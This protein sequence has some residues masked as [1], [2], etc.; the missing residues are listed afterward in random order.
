[1]KT[2]QPHIHEFGYPLR[3]T[4]EFRE[5]LK[6]LGF[7]FVTPTINRGCHWGVVYFFNED[8][9]LAKSLID[10]SDNHF[11]IDTETRYFYVSP[12]GVNPDSSLWQFSVQPNKIR[13]YKPIR[14]KRGPYH[15]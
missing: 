11:R 12:Y 2:Y 10:P 14:R 13:E 4:D 5:A 3:A 1:M 8:L 7:K 6:S 9:E 15:K